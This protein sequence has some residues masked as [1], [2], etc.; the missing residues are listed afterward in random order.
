MWLPVARAAKAG[1]LPI[2]VRSSE[3][4]G[5][6]PVAPTDFFTNAFVDQYNQFDHHAIIHQAARF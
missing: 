1:W 4:V 6:T 2:K 3:V 5:S